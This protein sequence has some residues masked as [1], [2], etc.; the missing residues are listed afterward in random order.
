M[1]L[2]PWRP[3]EYWDVLFPGINTIARGLDVAHGWAHSLFQS[4]G[5]QIW[6]ALF[7]ETRAAIDYAVRDVTLRQTHR[8]LDGV[9][10]ML[11]NGRWVV[12]N[13]VEQTGQ[14]V[15]GAI[16]NTG[17]LLLTAP[18]EAYRGLRNY[19]AELPGVNPA[20]RQQMLRAIE[21]QNAQQA[22]RTELGRD[23]QSVTP[24][25]KSSGFTESGNV[26]QRYMPPGGAMQRTCPDWM[27]PLILGLYGDIN[28]TWHTVIEEEYGPQKKRRRL[29]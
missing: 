17:Q 7:E 26:I 27:L 4:V 11:E 23:V 8:L 2:I 28:P 5:R 10:R 16:Q 18:S 19:Y 12:T 20:Q 24:S 21:R 25:P 29:Q 3:E 22:L 6:R 9:A 14:V 1:A 15:T 13:A